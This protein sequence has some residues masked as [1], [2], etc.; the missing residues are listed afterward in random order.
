MILV[1]IEQKEKRSTGETF[2]TYDARSFDRFCGG[3]F[4]K[5]YGKGGVFDSKNPR[6]ECNYVPGDDKICWKSTFDTKDQKCT[7]HSGIVGLIVLRTNLLLVILLIMLVV[8]VDLHNN[9]YLL[10]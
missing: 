7:K 1:I 5:Q 2:I 9:N 8:A 4:P 10:Y 6:R 3:S